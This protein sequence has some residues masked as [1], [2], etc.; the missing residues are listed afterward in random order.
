[1]WLKTATID[2]AI[3][4]DKLVW[5]LIYFSLLNFFSSFKKAFY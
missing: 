4:L 1:M 5:P 2:T 3:F